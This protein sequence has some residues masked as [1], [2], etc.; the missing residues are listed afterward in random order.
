M[1]GRSASPGLRDISAHAISWASLAIYSILTTT[2][3]FRATGQTEYGVWATVAAFRAGLLFVDGGLAFGLTRDAALAHA[4]DHD[5][6]ERL[7]ASVALYAASGAVAALVGI[8]FAWLPGTLLGL[9]A[10]L[11]EASIILTILMGFEVAM[12]LGFGPAIG[13]LRGLGRFDLLARTS[14]IQAALGTILLIALVP[15]FGL[16][17]AGAAAVTARF[18]GGASAVIAVRDRL[19]VGSVRLVGSQRIREVLTFA[20]PMW[21]VAVGS[22]LGI[23]TD[24]PVVG[25]LFGPEEAGAYGVGA[26]MPALVA[27]LV[28][29]LL[30]TAFPRLTTLARASTGHVVRILSTVGVVVASIGLSAMVLSAQ[31]ILHVWLGSAPDLAVTATSAYAV[32]WMINM[33]VHVLVLAAIARGV[34]HVIGP[35]VIGETVVNL[36]L[37]LALAALIGPPGPAVAS[38]ITA[39]LTGAVLLPV[40]LGRRVGIAPFRLLVPALAGAAFGILIAASLRLAVEG[41]SDPGVR[42]LLHAASTAAAI[43]IVGV[44]VVMRRSSAQRGLGIVFDGGWRVLRHERAER[45]AL[46]SALSDRGWGARSIEHPLVTV[47]IATYN[48]GPLVAERAISS[49]I[50]QTYRNIEILVIGDHCDPSTERA[51]RSVKDPRIRFENL[52]HRGRYP[53][54]PMFRWMVAGAAPMNRALQLARGEWI[55]PLDDDDEFTPDHVEVLLESCRERNL[56]AAYGVADMEMQPGVWEPVG[57][58]PPRTGAI[59]HSAV[60]YSLDLRSMPHSFE[61]WRL[62]EPG[63]WNLWRRMMAAGAE[64]GFVDQVVVRHYLESREVLAEATA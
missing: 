32:V 37:S 49:A 31:D 59:I 10:Q 22:A 17:G 48:R 33:P 39:A 58:W 54:D 60:L 20:L 47:R 7:R 28:F 4:D 62:N 18:A 29:V 55:A 35:V 57:S 11:Y 45:L 61:S 53:D 56:D 52:P 9:T 42:V 43:G 6:R 12:A 14:L 24:V 34:H 46:S 40:L 15:P 63:D 36:G 1:T 19:A 41:F 23:A 50:A 8:T 51:V 26:V 30:D 3:V 64:F 16:V 21:A 44:G 38:V 25:A 5:A 27:G 2:V 13:M